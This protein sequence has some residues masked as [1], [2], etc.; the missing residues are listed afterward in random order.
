MKEIA[1]TGAVGRKEQSG[2]AIGHEML[3]PADRHRLQ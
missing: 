3:R 1:L 2:K